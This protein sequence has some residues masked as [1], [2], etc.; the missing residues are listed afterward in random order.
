MRQ[1]QGNCP[2]DAAPRAGNQG[3]FILEW[4]IHFQ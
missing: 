4:Q 3:Y 1:A 2:P